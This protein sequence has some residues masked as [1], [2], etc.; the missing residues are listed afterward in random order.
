[1]VTPLGIAFHARAPYHRV[2]NPPPV[3]LGAAPDASPP[4]G[5]SAAIA[6]A[7]A[8]GAGSSTAPSATTALLSPGTSAAMHGVDPSWIRG[9]AEALSAAKA[10]GAYG[11]TSGLATM[12]APAAPLTPTAPKWA[13][14]EISGLGFFAGDSSRT[15]ASMQAY[16][17]E[18]IATAQRLARAERTLSEEAGVEIRIAY[19]P[20]T[21]SAV[22]LS[23]GDPGYDDIRGARA[24][25]ARMERDLALMGENPDDYRALLRL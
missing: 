3:K 5:A 17:R 18:E 14:E 21:D 8:A 13:Y 15:H 6:A 7:P 9:G 20:N 19:D 12:E 25:F 1:M 22:A 11:L 16:L 24:S 2:A 10:A 23:P 4:P